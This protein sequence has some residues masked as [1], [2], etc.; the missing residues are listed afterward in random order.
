MKKTFFIILL[1]AV[2]MPL[3]AFENHDWITEFDWALS[4]GRDIADPS[5][6]S[7]Q[8]DW[9]GFRTPIAAFHKFHIPS[10]SVLYQVRLRNEMFYFVYQTEEEKNIFFP[11]EK[12]FFKT[13]LNFEFN[14][15]FSVLLLTRNGR[16][17]TRQERVTKLINS[18]Y[19]LI[20]IWGRLPVLT[21]YGLVNHSDCLYY[22]EIERDIP[23][24]A[25][26]N[27]T[28]LF[29]QTGDKVFES[30][31][32]F[33]DGRMR[34]EI[35]SQTEI[36][37]TPLFTLPDEKGWVAPLRMRCSLYNPRFSREDY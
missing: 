20:G 18:E 34:L 26:R 35:K 5:A 31:S 21:E 23:G 36:I 13:P 9:I 30:I 24:Y 1:A 11:L 33:P 25:V 22:L 37:L 17:F 6:R 10:D 3:S 15:D 27:G 12:T 32:S 4:D 8:V 2:F 16:F 14:N 29:K 28:Y 19:P 7:S